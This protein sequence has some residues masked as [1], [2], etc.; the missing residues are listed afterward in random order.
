MKKCPQCKSTYSD[1]ELSFCLQDGSQLSAAF[2]SET[3]LVLENANLAIQDTVADYETEKL[4]ERLGG[5]SISESIDVKFLQFCGPGKPNYFQI[6]LSDA[7]KTPCGGMVS[8][9]LGTKGSVNGQETDGG[10]VQ[11]HVPVTGTVMVAIN[12]EE[13]YTVT[14]LDNA[15]GQFISASALSDH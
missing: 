5:S 14:F 11:V 12:V 4:T 9:L 10:P 1:D 6:F 3:T 7:A 2:D 8:V 13:D 15:S